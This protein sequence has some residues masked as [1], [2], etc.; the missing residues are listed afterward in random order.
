MRS[1]LVITSRKTFEELPHIHAKI[2]V[3]ALLYSNGVREHAEVQYYFV[4]SATT[5]VIQGS[6]VRR[7]YPDEESS[8]GFLKKAF[9]SK[10]PG[11]STRKGFVVRGMAIEPDNPSRCLPTEP[12]TYVVKLVEYSVDSH[13]GLPLSHLPPHHQVVVVNTTADRLKHGRAAIIK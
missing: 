8:I 2:L 13:C 6:K 10:A 4:D 5:V 7:L 3:A 9:S 11:A 12:F 1:F